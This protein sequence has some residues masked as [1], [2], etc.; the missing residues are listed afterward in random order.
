MEE[1]NFARL[2]RKR[3][4]R[5]HSDCVAVQT[6]VIPNIQALRFIA[7]F[8]VCVLH[9]GILNGVLPGFLMGGAGVDLFFV[10]SGF[11]MVVSSQSMF[12]QAG[13][14]GKFLYRRITR[15][16]PLY[17]LATLTYI[18]LLI[19]FQAL[20][21][22]PPTPDVYPR[23]IAGLFFIPLTTKVF[24]PFLPPGWTLNFEMLFY[25]IFACAIRFRQPFALMIIAATICFLPIIGI[26]C[27]HGMNGFTFYVFNRTPLEF[28]WGVGIGYFYTN[29]KSI[30]A[31]FAALLF[32]GGFVGVY[33]TAPGTFPERELSI[34]IPAAA[35]VAGGVYLP[36]IRSRTVNLLGDSSY[37]LYLLHW[38]F[39]WFVHSFPQAVLLGMAVVLAV[40]VRL[41]IE[42][43]LLK[44]LRG[45][46]GSP[47][48]SLKLADRS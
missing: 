14:P 44:L 40:A 16:V 26:T 37:A 20:S 39:F 6:G 21:L 29:G 25:L 23:A 41:L 34:G 3:S 32:A 8:G 48:L 31:M 19:H 15:V 24:A 10:I 18:A 35:I 9:C 43:P 13:A 28:L 27:F 12:G 22:N 46:L 4:V 42:A 2:S 45:S 36:Q 30:P 38:I 1:V 33:I 7:A 17:W 11:I 5:R 47:T